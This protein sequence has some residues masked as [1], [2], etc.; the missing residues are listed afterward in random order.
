MLI[1]VQN[2]NENPTAST[3]WSHD[4]SV[5]KKQED[6][7]LAVATEKDD[8]GANDLLVYDKIAMLMIYLWM[9]I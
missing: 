5:T 6:V 1:D 3:Y 9:I 8:D 7:L 2:L 4:T